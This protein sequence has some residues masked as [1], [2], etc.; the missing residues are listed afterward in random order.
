VINRARRL[1]ELVATSALVACGCGDGAAKPS[2]AT[3]TAEATVSGTV[4]S[5]GKPVSKGEILFDNP[6]APPGH[7]SARSAL[8]PKGRYSLKTQPGPNRVVVVIP[9]QKQPE[10]HPFEVKEGENSHDIA[11]SR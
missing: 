9:G 6:S 2:A 1:S 4:T 5:N 11:L 10:M 8:D 7:P 3:P